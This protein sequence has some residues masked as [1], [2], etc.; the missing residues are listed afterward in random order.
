VVQYDPF[1]NTLSAIGPWADANLYR[2]SSKELNPNSGL[3]YFLYRCYNPSVQR[4]VNGDPIDELGSLLLREVHTDFIGTAP[5]GRTDGLYTYVRNDPQKYNDPLGLDITPNGEVKLDSSCTKPMWKLNDDDPK[6]GWNW[7]QMG[8]PGR[9]EKTD[10]IAWYGPDGKLNTHKTPNGNKCKIHCDSQGFPKEGGVG[11][12]CER[13]PDFC[14][15]DSLGK[16]GDNFPYH[17]PYE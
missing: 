13:W 10:F 2:F 15:K 9:W 14:P 1:G 11:I 12:E 3:V 16:A 4:W 6:A 8:A 5:R 17:T 7:V